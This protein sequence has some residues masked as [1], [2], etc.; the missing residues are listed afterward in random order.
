MFGNKSTLSLFTD[1]AE[2]TGAYPFRFSSLLLSI[3]LHSAVVLFVASISGHKTGWI[4]EEPPFWPKDHTLVYY[5]LKR[6]SAEVSPRV[7]VGPLRPPQAERS[8]TRTIIAAEPKPLSSAQ[9]IL[10]PAPE[11]Q[12]E[13]NLPTVIARLNSALPPLPKLPAPPAPK[14]EAPKEVK[15]NP[16][17]PQPQGDPKRAP[18][19]NNDAVE[20]PK[21]DSR[22]FLPPKPSTVQPRLPLPTPVTDAGSP[23][24]AEPAMDARVPAGPGAPA[25][26]VAAAPLSAAPPALIA[27]VGN[28]NSDVVIAALNP[29]D[30]A[31]VEA[32]SAEQPGRFSIAPAAGP[33]SSGN[34]GKAGIRE[35]NLTTGE[36]RS[37]PK[38]PEVAPAMKAVLYAERVR[39]G[40]PPTFAAPLRP[41]ARSLPRAVEARFPG[42]IVFTFVAPIENFPAYTGDWILWYA[43]RDQSPSPAAVVRAPVP[44]KKMEPVEQAGSPRQSEM[45]IQLAAVVSKNGT[46]DSVLLLSNTTATVERAVVQDITSWQFTPATRNG[47]PVDVDVV[48]E[49]PFNLAA[50]K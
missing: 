4:H 48:F 20:L 10:Q 39:F 43:E 17:P 26:S 2:Q 28:S 12:I 14:V 36:E 8:S 40:T 29:S 46:L 23:T 13:P 44:Y 49:I 30:K 9:L 25:S 27:N 33:V 19:A 31:H 16:S 45:R 5:S 37:K 38:P 3:C 15:P 42:R 47:A 35:S 6:K 41:G 24:V 34:T 1:P 22:P 18:E 7:L 21:R 11:I 32:P 50:P